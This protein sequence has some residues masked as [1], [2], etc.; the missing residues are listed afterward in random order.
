[1]K[2]IVLCL[3]LGFISSY[4]GVVAQDEIDSKREQLILQEAMSQFRKAPSW[5][6]LSVLMG[7]RCILQHLVMGN[8]HD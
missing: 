4:G 3:M 6:L 5:F 2:S 1:M 8:S 7:T